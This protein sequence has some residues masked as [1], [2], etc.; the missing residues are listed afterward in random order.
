MLNENIIRESSSP[1]S[2]PVWMVP[3]KLDASGKRKFRMVIDYRKLN[4]KTVDDKFPIPNITEILDRLGRNVYY[5]TLDLASGFHQLQMSEDSIPKTAFTS[6][7]GH[8]EFLRMPFGLKNAPATFQRLMNYILKDYINKICLVYL[9]DIIILGTSLQE[10]I[11]NIQKIFQVL[12][13]HNLKIQLDKS[14]FLRKEVAYLGHIVSQEGVKPNP[15][16]IKAVKEYPI[17]K[18][19]KEIKTYLGLLGYYRKF[20]PNFAKLTKPMTSC[21]KKGN[22]VDINHSDYRTS[23]E[24]SKELLI[25][26][27]I[28]QYPDFNKQFTLTTDA[29]NYAIGAVLSQNYEGKDLPIAYASRTLNEHEINY[30]TTEKELLGIVWSTKY[31]RPYLYGTKFLIH[32][33]HRPLVWLMSLKDPNS[34][35]MRWKIKLDEYNFEISYKKGTLNNN[36]DALSRIRQ[37]FQIKE[38]DKDIFAEN[39]NLV[40]CISSDKKLDVGFAKQIESKFNSTKYLIKQNKTKGNILIQPIYNKNILFH[41]ITKESNHDKLVIETIQNCLIELRNYC[42]QNDIFEL[43]MSKL[44][45]EQDRINFEI[46][47]N[48]LIKTFKDTHVQITIHIPEREVYINDNDSVAPQTSETNYD[49]C[50]SDEENEINGVTYKDVAINIGKNQLII[51]THDLETE[52]RVNKLFNQTKQRLIVKLN[53]QNL[54]KEIIDFIKNYLAPKC[55]YYGLFEG[56]LHLKF[57]EILQ[58]NFTKDSYQLVKCEH[59]LEDKENKDEQIETIMNYHEGKTNHRGILETYQQLKRKFYWPNLYQNI[60]KYINNCELCQTNKYER[61]PYQLNDNLTK[62]PSQPFQIINIDTL[63]LEREKY[64]T[65][66]DQFSKFGQAYYLKNLDAITVT[67]QLLNYFNTYKIPDEIIHDSGTEFNNNLIKELLKMY[68]IEI[69]MTCVDNPKSN[70]CVERFHSTLIE[71]LRIINQRNEF[72]NASKQEKIKFAL[73]GYNNSVNSITQLTP[74]ETIFGKEQSK[75]IFETEIATEDCLTNY[76][77]RL[78][79]IQDRVKQNIQINKNKRFLLQKRN[80]SKPK[81]LPNRILIKEGRRRIQKIKKPLFKIH[82]IEKYDPALGVVKINPHKRH[83][84][85]KIKRPRLYVADAQADK[86]S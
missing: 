40:H 22:K 41:L 36:A 26:A 43:H 15:S 34:K 74:L 58:N 70:G 17:P 37:Q 86:K 53:K 59:L 64:L 28:L 75:N 25:N 30:S 11:E 23:F 78:K 38:T 63:T 49:T 10:H 55:K 48:I 72:K 80:F 65:I 83:K 82:K 20:I 13:Q 66:I 33:D 71:H 27:P 45:F 18:T 52:I 8:Y 44:C 73:I 39:H 24:H 6:E 51:S 35:L 62:T 50:H 69:H 21:L 81:Q 12:R 32:T 9:D 1:W 76:K 84:I 19:Q 60:Q 68:K 14:E 46:I 57:N 16:K 79:Q 67:K 56:N 77:N 29:S 4:S 2:S 61:N 42:I 5:T 54:E 85:D 3:K 31:F 7:T 47:K